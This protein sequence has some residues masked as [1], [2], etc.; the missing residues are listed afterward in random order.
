MHVLTE[1]PGALVYHIRRCIHDWSDEDSIKILTHLANAMAPDSK[2]L[3]SELVMTNPPGRFAAMSSMYMTNIG[4]KERTRDE[5][6]ELCRRSGLKI[7][8]IVGKVG[9]DISVIVCVKA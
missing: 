1:N 8:D 3:I 9:T 5:F 7:A 6:E 4:G 2:L